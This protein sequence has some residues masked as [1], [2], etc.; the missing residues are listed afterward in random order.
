MR[1]NQKDFIEIDMLQEKKSY[2]TLKILVMM[3]EILK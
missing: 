2:L 1:K 3:Y